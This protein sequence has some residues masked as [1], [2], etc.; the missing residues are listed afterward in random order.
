ML[1]LTVKDETNVI[2]SNASGDRIGEIKVS[3]RRDGRARIGFD[4]PKDIIITRDNAQPRNGGR[5]DDGKQVDD[6]R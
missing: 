4:L 3:V 2:L 1:V 6:V 5:H